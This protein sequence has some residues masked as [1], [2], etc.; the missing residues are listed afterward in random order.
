VG[1]F[2]FAYEG[3]I[4]AVEIGGFACGIV[5]LAKYFLLVIKIMT[6]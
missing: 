2:D 5:I 3:F 4:G 6:A 1:G